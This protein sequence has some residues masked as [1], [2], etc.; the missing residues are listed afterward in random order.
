MLY[1]S[2]SQHNQL[3]VFVFMVAAYSMS[4]IQGALCYMFISRRTGKSYAAASTGT[5]VLGIQIGMASLTY[6]IG[7]VLEGINLQ[8]AQF[9]FYTL[10]VLIFFSWLFYILA[11]I[12]NQRQSFR[13]C[14]TLP[15]K[16]VKAEGKEATNFFGYAFSHY[17]YGLGEPL[18]SIAQ[19]RSFH[20][21]SAGK[22]Q[23][24]GVGGARKMD[25]R[26]F[27]A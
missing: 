27:S 25:V 20:Q 9:F 24:G 21:F 3:L 5:T 22:D 18:L 12:F 11:A 4:Q 7:K 13:G 6:I 14:K 2:A 17:A 10:I 16:K 1:Y 8:K 19:S 23:D 15:G 26:K